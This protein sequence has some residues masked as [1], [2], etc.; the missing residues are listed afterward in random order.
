MG[1]FRWNVK[2]V[3]GASHRMVC[4]SLK[5]FCSCL[6]LPSPQHMPDR[7]RHSVGHQYD[8]PDHSYV[9]NSD[10]G[11]PSMNYDHRTMMTY[12]LYPLLDHCEL[13]TF[14]CVNGRPDFSRMSLY[15]CNGL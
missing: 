7:Q 10:S 15:G 5:R 9:W 14:S 4:D 3:D 8:G 1:C 6:Q 13:M 12:V 11:Q 2:V